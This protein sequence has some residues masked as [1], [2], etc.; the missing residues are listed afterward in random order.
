MCPRTESSDTGAR[1]RFGAEDGAH[2]APAFR[3]GSRNQR[4]LGSIKPGKAFQFIAVG[5][6]VTLHSTQNYRVLLNYP[7]NIVTMLSFCVKL[8]A[9]DFQQG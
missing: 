5:Y 8:W 6:E 2:L 9:W 7:P 4:G 3:L 1:H